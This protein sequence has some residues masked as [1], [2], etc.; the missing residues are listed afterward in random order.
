MDKIRILFFGANPMFS[1]RLQ[2][3]EEARAITQ[4]L[5]LAKHRDKVE[6]ITA[7]AVRSDDLLQLLNEHKPHIVHF[8]GHG[9][10]SGE[11]ILVMEDGLNNPVPP[12]TIK[13]LFGVVKDNLRVVVFNACF[14]EA[15]A[16]AVI[17][18][19]DCA[20]GMHSSIDDRAASI[21]AAS[22]Y[23][24]IGFGRSVQQA[25]DQ[26]KTAMLLEG[27]ELSQSK[28]PVLLH[29]TS[30]NPSQ[31][32]L[33]SEQNTKKS[34]I[35]SD[36]FPP[37]HN[38]VITGAEVYNVDELLKEIGK[39]SSK[40]SHL[41]LVYIDI[42]GLLGINK[43]YGPKIGND[44]ISVVFKTLK[45]ACNPQQIYRFR[46]DQ[47]VIVLPDY[48]I[49]SA[50]KIAKRCDYRVRKYPWTLLAPDLFASCTSCIATRQSKERV[51]LWL[52]RAIIGL[53]EAK[54]RGERVAQAPQTMMFQNEAWEDEEYVHSYIS[55]FSS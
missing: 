35:N 21:F 42:D 48:D 44:V 11:L 53:K 43:V 41:S 7:W 30:V 17:E 27:F 31:I 13:A 10:S 46:G 51:S 2:L 47:F 23:R 37:R 45:K 9:G 52:L 34:I 24:A 19:I 14:S 32:F 22:F 26:G 6:F 50:I 29:R 18:V 49:E 15:Q 38:Y 20:I 25:F 39:Y 12:E 8:S 55:S 36:N 1:P 4:K 16:K 28:I 33:C 5:R 54:K 3:D 40:Y